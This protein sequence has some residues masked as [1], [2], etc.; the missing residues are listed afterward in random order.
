MTS[1]AAVSGLVAWV[2]FL[3]CAPAV[4]APTASVPAAPPPSPAP[5]HRP[6]A[7]AYDIVHVSPRV[8]VFVAHDTRSP[9]VSGN[10]TAIVGDDAVLVVDTGQFPALARRMVEDLRRITDK[11]V[12]VVVST[13]WHNDHVFGNAVYRDAFASR[14]AVRFLAHEETKRLLLKNG[15]KQVAAYR[16]KIGPFVEGL[17]AQLR[18]G[19]A[20]GDSGAPLTEDDRRALEE[21]IAD[22]EAAIPLWQEVELVTPTETFKD[23]VT[24]PLGGCDV[25]VLHF[26]RGNTAGDAMVWVPDA[27][28]LVTGDVVVAPTPFAIGSYPREWRAVLAKMQALGARTLVPGHGAVMRD[29]ASY[30][31]DLDALLATVDAQV[32]GAVREGRSLDDARKSVDL[33]AVGRKVVGGDPFHARALHDYFQEPAVGRAFEEAQGHLSDE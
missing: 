9:I 27:K 17:K 26:G 29:G 1:R 28:V 5:L 20:D 22:G 33:G 16:T 21:K 7:D 23:E 2:V 30:V 31:A 12:K 4:V 25:R 6:R 15:P 8:H 32:A 3:A 18:S 13:H 19:N 11:P 24:I 10:S 14:G